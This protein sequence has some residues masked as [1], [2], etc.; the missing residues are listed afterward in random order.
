MSGCMK[1]PFLGQYCLGD[2]TVRIG[3]Y[4]L[5]LLHPGVIVTLLLGSTLYVYVFK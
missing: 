3:G 5:D 2:L 1:L 4:S